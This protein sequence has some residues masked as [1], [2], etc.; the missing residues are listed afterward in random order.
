MWKVTPLEFFYCCLIASVTVVGLLVNILGNYL[1]TFILQVFRYGKHSTRAPKSRLVE[2]LEVPKSYFKHFYVFAT[3]VTG[4]TFYYVVKAYVLEQPPPRELLVGLDILSGSQ[5]KAKGNPLAI[6]LAIF[7]LLIQCLRRLHE[8]HLM[9][10][11]SRTSRMNVAHYFVGHLHYFLA[12]VAILAHAPG[13][14]TSTEISML[15]LEQLNWRIIFSG[16]VFFFAWWQQWCTNCILARLRK[17]KKGRVV[18]EK[19]LIPRGG[20]F[21][22][23]S[24]PH[25]FFECVM[26]TAL[27]PALA[28]NTDWLLVTA[29]VIA[30]QVQ[31]AYLTHVWYRTTFAKYPKRRRALIP[32]IF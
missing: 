30:N 12:C 18:T 10:I 14:V 24:S 15:S 1:P 13:F 22:L 2:L 4:V 28:G 27:I 23:I 3:F 21:D 32:G 19:H 31:V 29:W 9:Q 6:L 5:R 16:G 17:N 7:C 25:M 20:F 11:F 26:Y 8:T